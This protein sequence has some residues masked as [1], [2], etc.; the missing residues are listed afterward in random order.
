MKH[1]FVGGYGP[2][3]V[4]VDPELAVIASVAAQKASF[5]APHPSLPVLYAVGEAD[6]GLVSAYTVA[7]GGALTPLAER[8]SEG[9]Q[10]CH[11]AVHPGGEVLAVANYGD[12]TVSLHRLDGSGAF[13]GEPVVLTHTGSG[14]VAE[15]QE[16]SHAHQ[17]VFH[18]DVL[19]VA[20]L[21]TDEIR[22]Y[23]PGGAALEPVR[24]PAGMGPR[25]LVFER[26]RCHVA[27]ELDAMVRTYDGVWTEVAA[28]PASEEPGTNYPSHIDVAGPYVYVGNRGP[29]TVSV[30]RA[31]DLKK[32][33]EVPSGGS[34]PRHFAIDGET[35]YVAN[36]TSNTVALLPLVK[37]L[38]KPA[39]RTFGVAAPACV[40]PR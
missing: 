3:L 35:M 36:Q 9:G 15:R 29:D 18:E 32:V 28:A 24:L 14:P 5:L 33:A 22:R 25:H 37:G 20:D 2:D 17:A 8:S 23:T 31:D 34:W 1:L 10:P 27:G 26:G 21:G 12:G 7:E 4:T 11:L 38:P 39:S 19:Y 30:L 6:N 16:C 40:L 13:A